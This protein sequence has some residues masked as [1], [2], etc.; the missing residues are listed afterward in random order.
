MAASWRVSRWRDVF[1]VTYFA[2]I[3]E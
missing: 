1:G 2:D 3:A